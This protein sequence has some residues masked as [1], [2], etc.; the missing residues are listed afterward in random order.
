M[1]F[2]NRLNRPWG[3]FHTGEYL[4]TVAHR[5]V[6]IGNEGKAIY[7]TCYT[8]LSFLVCFFMSVLISHST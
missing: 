3:G 2:S 6:G 8:F 1:L 5:T 4:L 7:F